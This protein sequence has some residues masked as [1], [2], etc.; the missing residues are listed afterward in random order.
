MVLSYN[1]DNRGWQVEET[2]IFL[3][4][5]CVPLPVRKVYIKSSFVTYHQEEDKTLR[6]QVTAYRMVLAFQ[7]RQ[8]FVP[9]VILAAA[10]SLGTVGQ[11]CNEQDYQGRLAGIVRYQ[12]KS[13]Q[14]GI[15]RQQSHSFIHCLCAQNDSAHSPAVKP[16]HYPLVC[17]CLARDRPLLPL[18]CTRRWINVCVCVCIRYDQVHI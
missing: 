8:L 12:R 4:L 17:F 15:F 11:Q 14:W 2:L 5:L 6:L 9:L 13:S 18:A 10:A 7:W 16:C 1:L 3:S